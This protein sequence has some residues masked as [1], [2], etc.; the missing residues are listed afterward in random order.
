[1]AILVHESIVYAPPA[2]SPYAGPSVFDDIEETIN[3]IKSEDEN[4]AVFLLGDFNARTGILPDVSH[5]YESGDQ[6]VELC[7]IINSN[8]NVT[9]RSNKDQ[10]VNNMG[11]RL[12]ELC[13][14]IDLHIVN[15]RYGPDK[16]IGKTT[17]KNASV[18]NYILI[19]ENLA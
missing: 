14:S 9:K 1:M 4:M 5:N 16:A 17:C 19:S 12:I 6:S 2:D 7:E 10:Y 11:K 8:S 13:N 3:N 18:V 15:G